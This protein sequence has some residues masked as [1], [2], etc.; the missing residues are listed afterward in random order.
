M[1]LTG[2]LSWLFLPV[3]RERITALFHWQNDVSVSARFVLWNRA[4]QVFKESP[5]F[6]IGI[7]H[8]PHLRIEE[9]LKQGHVALDHAHSNYLHILATTGLVGMSAYLY[10]WSS[11]IKLAYLN[12]K[13]HGDSSLEQGICLGIFAGLISLVIS[14]LFEYN[15]GTGQVRLAQWFL[16]AML[17]TELRTKMIN[18]TTYKIIMGYAAVIQTP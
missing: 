5:I 9:A 10:L 8:F 17:S 3:V 7:R 12:Q 13:T 1:V 11:A 6:G 14:G 15:F 18:R 16:L 2:A 4:W